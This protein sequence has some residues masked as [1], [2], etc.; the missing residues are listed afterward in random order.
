MIKLFAALVSSTLLVVGP[1]VLH[2]AESRLLA[3]DNFAEALQVD[4]PQLSP[5]GEWVAYSV[6]NIDLPADRGNRSLWMVSWNGTQQIRLTHG[7]DAAS[8]PRWSPDGRYLSFLSSRS[9]PA[10]GRQI[11]VIDRRGGEARQLTAL[12]GQ[13][14]DYVWSPDSSRLAVVMKKN[15]P[16]AGDPALRPI[17]IERYLF[18]SDNEGYLTGRERRRIYLYDL[19][20][21][22]SEPLTAQDNVEEDDPTWSHDGTQIAFSSNRAADPDRTQNTDIYVAK[23]EAGSVPRRLTSFE[24]PDTQP[25]WSPDGRDIAYLQGSPLD[26]SGYNMDRLAVVSTDGGTPRLLTTKLDREIGDPRFAA[27]G[28]FI[29]FLVQDDQSVYPARVSKEG[30]DIQRTVPGALVVG[31]YTRAGDRVAMLVATDNTLPEI[32]AFE[33]GRLRKLTAH[34]DAWL[35]RV[36]LGATEEIKFKAADGVEVHGLLVKPPGYEAGKKYPTLFRL[37]GGPHGQDTRSFS[38]ER[39]LFAAQGYVVVTINYRGSS[40]RGEKFGQAIFRNWGSKDVT[41]VLSGADHVVRLGVADPARLGIG[42]WSYGGILTNFVIAHDTRFKAAISGAGFGNDL[43]LYGVNQYIFKFERE[44]G[45]PWET[46]TVAMKYS[47]PFFNADRIRTPTLFLC[48]EKDFNVPLVGSEQMYQALRSLEVPT[49][50]V[51]YP[52]EHHGISRPSFV[53][54]RYQRYLDW[55]RSHLQ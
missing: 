40:G 6:G 37:H 15:E 18:K 52:N 11:W 23:A 27:D 31:K 38:F 44:I 21:G 17:V 10:A 34:N 19:A 24:G 32:H 55:Y 7:T 22:R 39:Q 16:A 51:I 2:A 36:R 42:G 1:S 13:I 54:D 12:S 46:T 53:R 4:D 43:A 45:R 29:D 30:G 20:S 26:Y 47:Y 33:S 50:L 48:G 3:V 41:D 14:G 25:N 5:D 49:Q 9:G 35:A 8:S 28:R